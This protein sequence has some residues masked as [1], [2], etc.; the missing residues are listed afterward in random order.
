MEHAS[1][2][3]CT[4]IQPGGPRAIASDMADDCLGLRERKHRATY[5]AIENTTLDLLED[6]GYEAV[7]IEAICHEVGISTRT[8]FNYFPS[9]D[10]A[11]VGEGPSGLTASQVADLLDRHA[12]DLLAALVVALMTGEQ[13]RGGDRAIECRRRKVLAADPV[14]A[15]RHVRLGMDFGNLLRT[16]AAGYLS[17]HPEARRLGVPAACEADLVLSVAFVAVR[18]A[19]SLSEEEADVALTDAEAALDR[20]RNVLSI[21]G[22]PGA[23]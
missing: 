16:V 22:H 20:M 19:F 21:P 1:A 9:K 13:A 6:G 8:F 23:P 7:T 17:S 2:S 5:L 11:I 4:P 3:V 15:W 10:A 18:H 14:L 12:P